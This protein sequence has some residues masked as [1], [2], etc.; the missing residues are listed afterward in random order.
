M[1]AVDNQSLQQHSSDLLLDDLLQRLPPS[2]LEACTGNTWH[3]FLSTNSTSPQLAEMAWYVLQNFT[4]D[5]PAALIIFVTTS[6][7]GILLT[8]RYTSPRRWVQDGM[9]GCQSWSLPALLLKR[10]KAIHTRSSACDCWDSGAD[11][12][13]RW[14]TDSGPQCQ[15]RWPSFEKSP[16]LAS[17]RQ[18]KIQAELA[19]VSWPPAIKL[20]NINEFRVWLE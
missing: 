10:G 12:P 2:G 4:P 8:Q 15:V 3:T 20:V 7:G 9:H 5:G 11:L 17:A 19:S 6:E 1:G 13:A 16:L 18:E 14:E